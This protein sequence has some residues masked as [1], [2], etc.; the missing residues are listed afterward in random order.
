MSKKYQL[1]CILL[2]LSL[3]I[4]VILSGFLL[5]P[6]APE[7]EPVVVE[8]EDFTYGAVVGRGFLTDP[9]D[10]AVVLDCIDNLTLY[11]EEDK[12]RIVPL[13]GVIRIQ[14]YRNGDIRE[15]SFAGSYYEKYGGGGQ[16]KDHQDP[17]VKNW[18]RSPTDITLFLQEHIQ[19]TYPVPDWG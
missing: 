15:Y 7:P 11:E 10:I 4:N 13:G 16:V 12:D 1:L 2:F 5:Q 19:K 6:K 14:L 8:I 3:G 9:E 18:Y 17:N